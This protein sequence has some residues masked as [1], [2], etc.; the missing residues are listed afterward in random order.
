MTELTTT[1]QETTKVDFLSRPLVV[2]LALD[3]EKS[4]YL[5]F[6]VLTLVSRF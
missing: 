3:W 1:P 2:G 4:L 6:I 5:L